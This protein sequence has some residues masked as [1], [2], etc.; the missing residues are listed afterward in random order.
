[1]NLKSNE[2]SMAL[3]IEGNTFYSQRN[4]FSAM[5]KYNE[6]LCFAEPESENVGLAYA[7]RSAV[8]VEQKYYDKCLRN[9]GLA[10]RH[11]YPQ[12]N[13]AILDKREVKCKEL[14]KK[15]K[16]KL[17]D[18]WNYFKLSYPAHKKVPFIAECL[19]LK[20]SEKF[21]RYIITNRPLKVGDIL[22]IEKPFC[23]VLLAESKFHEIPDS[24]V[25]QR[26]TGC[27]KENGL[28]LTPCMSCCKGSLEMF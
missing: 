19:E 25:Y 10:K 16:L 11:R 17:S 21:G 14:M 26:C 13:Y 8:Y 6:S 9:I 18:P 4:F 5:L 20:N 24:N 7:N 3:R 15:E 2:K 22:S 1:M 23:N 12:S 28:D 27:L